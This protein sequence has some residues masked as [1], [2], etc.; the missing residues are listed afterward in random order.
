VWTHPLPTQTTSLYL[1]KELGVKNVRC[2]CLSPGAIN[3]PA[4]R[5]IPHFHALQ[6]QARE[7]SP[8]G[9]LV[10]SEEVAAVA[11]FLASDMASGITGQVIRVDAGESVHSS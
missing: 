3:T 9:R 2:N 5:G 11:V 8:L 10:R 4:A 7:R 1:S 6:A